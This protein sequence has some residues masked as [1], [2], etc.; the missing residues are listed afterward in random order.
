MTRGAADCSHSSEK[1]SNDVIGPAHLRVASLQQSSPQGAKIR[2]T[3]AA[4]SLMPIPV[5]HSRLC[6]NYPCPSWS[7]RLGKVAKK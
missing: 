1:T 7:N 5:G 2:I 6:P 3:E 4:L